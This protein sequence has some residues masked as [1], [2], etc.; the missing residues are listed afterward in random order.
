TAI[1]KITPEEAEAQLELND[2]I[3]DEEQVHNELRDMLRKYIPNLQY[4]DRALTDARLTDQI[5]Y[6]LLLNFGTFVEPKVNAIRNRKLSVEKFVSFLVQ[7]GKQLAQAGLTQDINEKLNK[8]TNVFRPQINDYEADQA[9]MSHEDLVNQLVAINLEELN[10]LDITETSAD[11][12]KVA[13]I[14]MLIRQLM[15]IDRLAYNFE[16][17]KN[18]VN[19][20]STILFSP[21]EISKKSITGNKFDLATLYNRYFERITNPDLYAEVPFAHLLKAYETRMKFYNDAKDKEAVDGQEPEL[22]EDQNLNIKAKL[23][24]DFKPPRITDVLPDTFEDMIEI[25]DDIQ[26]L[27][28]RNN[29]NNV[30]KNI[31]QNRKDKHEELKDEMEYYKREKTNAQRLVDASKREITKIETSKT[32]L[33]KK[34]KSE[35]SRLK[36]QIAESEEIIDYCDDKIE[37]LLK[38]MNKIKFNDKQDVS[39]DINRGKEREEDYEMG[40]NDYNANRGHRSYEDADV[41]GDWRLF[42]EVEGEGLRKKKS[43]SPASEM[44]SRAKPNQYEQQLVGGKYFINRKKLSANVL[45]IRYTKNRHLIP[46]KSQIVGKSLRTII[47]EIIDSNNLDKQKYEKLTKLEQNLLRSLLPYLGRDIDDVDDDEAFYDRFDVI[48]GELLS[49]NDNKMLKREAKQYLMH[50]L[51]TGKISRTHFNQMII[52]LDL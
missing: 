36:K 19:A 45:E 25:N 3:I 6:D 32:N 29:I 42:G 15:H 47:E 40:R 33:S 49:G 31:N 23:D 48:R 22:D 9:G 43:S 17:A 51:N 27:G 14:V 13:T 2:N 4:L 11:G 38:R 8:L 26:Y 30:L 20:G 46:I 5:K 21:D 10:A 39:N 50:A 1:G 37:M 18:K 12:M 52:D 44:P 28:R 7:L 41:T 35:R 24:K 16:R 34:D